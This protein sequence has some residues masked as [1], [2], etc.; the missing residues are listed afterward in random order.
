[1][2][3]FIAFATIFAAVVIVAVLRDGE[4]KRFE[5]NNSKKPEDTTNGS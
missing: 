2:N 1:M 5:E 3:F 4:Y